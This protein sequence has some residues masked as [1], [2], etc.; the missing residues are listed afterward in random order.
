MKIR[1]YFLLI[2]LILL[3]LYPITTFSQG[4]KDNKDP[5]K[6]ISID[7]D[8]KLT[9]DLRKIE[10]RSFINLMAKL[11]DLIAIMGDDVKGKVTI[12]A[13]QKL[14]MEGGFEVLMAVLDAKGFTILRS[15]KFLKVVRKNE[16]VQKPID[17]SFGADPDQ[18]P[19]ED[20]VITQVVPIEFGDANE[21]LNNIR[22]LI[23]STGNAFVNKD[24]NSLILTDVATNIKRMLILV[25]HLDKPKPEVIRG[26]TVVYAVRYMK[27]KDISDALEKVYGSKGASGDAKKNSQEFKV[28]TVEA[29]NSLIITTT[30]GM[31]AEIKKTLASLDIRLRQVLIEV[32]IAE[33]T[34]I[35]GLSFSNAITKYMEIKGDTTHSAKFGSS[36]QN[37][38]ITYEFTSDNL[39]GILEMF[40]QDDE[41]RILSSPRILS[42]DNQKAKI[43]VGQEQPILKS[44]TDVS[45]SGDTVSDFIFKDI[46]LELEVTP[47]INVDRDVA[48]EVSFK[49]TSILRFEDVGDQR[50]P[51]IGKREASSYVTVKDGNTLVIG[52]LIENNTRDLRNKVPIL[53]DL[54]VLGWLFSTI[55]KT[56]EQTELLLFITPHVVASANEGIALT[57]KQSELAPSA[58]AK[59]KLKG[60]K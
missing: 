7:K 51:V 1:H 25:D 29:V 38:F 55:N 20:R 30:K 18:I 52:G 46:G 49:I 22:P 15:E 2:P 6:G 4:N 41:L 12:F 42:S 45:D 9:L 58:V 33:A 10:L 32:K 57:E 36:I 16:A 19:N 27:A 37:P 11:N 28:T 8:G 48:L 60:K 34:F 35:D 59:T 31:H 14:D 13:P 39:A 54:P 3:F 26:E 50:Q 47:H 43:V 40:R 17:V 5:N 23:S 44:T 53:G 24:S 21:I 56:N